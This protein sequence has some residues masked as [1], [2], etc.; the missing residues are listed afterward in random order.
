MVRLF[1]VVIACLLAAACG[2]AAHRT[3]AGA[4][5][6]L[7]TGSAAELRAAAV[8]YVDAWNDRDAQAMCAALDPDAQTWAEK[9]GEPYLP[10]RSCEEFVHLNAA[11]APAQVRVVRWYSSYSVAGFQGL[12]AKLRAEGPSGEAGP[13]WI[14]FFF[15]HAGGK[16][17]LAKLPPL[18]TVASGDDENLDN[19]LP[20]STPVTAS[21]PAVLPAQAVE[22]AGA[23]VHAGDPAGDVVSSADRSAT[24]VSAPWLDIREVTGDGLAGAHPCVAVTLAAP[25]RAPFDLRISGAAPFP[26]EI[27]AG[28]GRAFVYQGLAT[29][30][31]HPF[32]EHGSTIVVSLPRA[33]QPWTLRTLT[34]CITAPLADE[35]ALHTQ[36]SPVDG[37]SADGKP[38]CPYP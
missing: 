4:T 7:T 17:L 31:G 5:G 16:P 2:A 21:K 24:P 1:L 30:G 29:T 20:P 23:V 37:W 28:P 27:A 33:T 38:D 34:V 32:G 13:A 18:A 10:A 8:S 22:C 14:S 25:A 12:Q 3:R 26:A 19:D 9:I 15:E 11:A 6:S 35:P 36:Q